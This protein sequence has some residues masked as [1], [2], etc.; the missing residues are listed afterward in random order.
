M[1]NKSPKKPRKLSN[2]ELSLECLKTLRNLK[3]HSGMSGKFAVE[4]GIALLES[5]LSATHGHPT[6]ANRPDFLTRPNPAAVEAGKVK[7]NKGI[8]L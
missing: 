7:L 8:V 5:S 3:R 6:L 1:S 2:F 4:R